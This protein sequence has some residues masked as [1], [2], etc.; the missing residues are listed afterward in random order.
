MRA[1]VP[2][3]TTH[4]RASLRAGNP[5]IV[6]VHGNRKDERGRSRDERERERDG[7]DR[8]RRDDGEKKKRDERVSR[9]DYN[10]IAHGQIIDDASVALT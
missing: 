6:A 4:V 5:G 3:T 7:G 10:D 1:A 2:R 9:P 8:S